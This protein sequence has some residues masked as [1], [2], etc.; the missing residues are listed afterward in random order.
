MNGCNF[1]DKKGL[2]IYPVRYAVASPYGAAGVP[3]LSGNFKIEGAPQSA[4]GAKYSLRALRPGYLYTYD[5]KRGRLKAYVVMPTGHLWH[6]P[7]EYNAPHPA[8][9]RFACIDPGELVRAYCVDIV[10]TASDPAGNFWIGWSNVQWT[11]ALL[12]KV[13]DAGWRKKHMQCI[14]IPAMLAGSAAHTGEF[15]ASAD[16]VAHFVADEATMKKA[17]AFSNTPIESE[18]RKLASAVRF[19]AIMAEH[20]PHHKGYIA[21]LNDPVGMTNDLSELT[22]PDLQAGFDE[23]LHQ[24]KMI[25]DLLALTEHHVR[26][27]AR[28][29]VAFRDAVA[30]AATHHP[31]GDVYNGLKTLGAMFKLGGIDRHEKKLREQRKKYGEDLAGRQ[32]AAADDAWHEL[33]HDNDKPILDEARLKAFPAT[34]DAALKEFEPRLMQLVMAHLGWLKSEQLANWME[35]VHDDADIRSGYAYSE[36]MAQCIGKATCSKPCVDQLMRWISSDNLKDTRNL[37]GR[38]LLLN[39][40]D[41]IAATEI[42]LKGSDIQIENILN[43][44]KGAI[45]RLHNAGHAEQLIDRLALTTGNVIAKAISESGSLLAKG[46]AHIHLQLMAGVAIK[47]SNMS[48][49]DVARWAIAEAKEQ[50]IK[51]ETTRQKTRA[52]ART[53]AGRAVKRAKVEK[54]VVY[55]LDIARLEKEGRIAPGSIKGIGLPG[56]AMTQKWLG[57]GV[58]RDFRLGVVT[59]IVQM[60]AL[61]FAM[62]DLAGNDHFNQVETRFKAAVAAVSLAATLVETIAV[63]V[64][65]SIEHPL[66]AFIRDQWKIDSKRAG[67]I[68]KMA[69][70][71]GAIAGVLAGLYDIFYNARN[72]DKEGDKVLARLYFISGLVGIALPAAIYLSIGAI[73][74]PLFVISIGIGIAIASLNDSALK[75]WI[76]RC[77]FSTG[78][79]YRSFDEQLSSF[80]RAVGA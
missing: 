54:H 29:E 44:Y 18:T 79:K 22:I 80:E 3:G 5:E 43:I 71:V 31:D 55:E 23:K 53:E 72:A 49:T 76:A 51:M 27:E 77:E 41:I 26:Q 58:P 60:V 38:A 35:G 24:G 56:F 15:N 47:V 48:S 42:Q 59:M 13:S 7:L 50:G 2:L 40:A 34:Y 73:F 65:K 4:G 37:Y 17:Y 68:A 28:Q 70:R 16:K 57:S 25:A 9:I 10:H 64:E 75:I 6:Y 14:D 46:L 61:N 45:E 67:R 63:S 36:S 21:A 11:K 39:Q 1:C 78:D 32:Q 12:K 19:K 69:Q 62:K 20:G 8:K 74:W 66:G 30:E 33:T 52:D